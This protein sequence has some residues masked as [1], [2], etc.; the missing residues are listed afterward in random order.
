MERNLVEELRGTADEII[1]RIRQLIK[2]GSARRLLIK[3]QKGKVLM[4]VP[5]T[6]GVAGSTLIIAMAPVISAISMFALFIND[7]D[8]LVEK[9]PEAGENG[10]PN[11]K[12]EKEK[13]PYEVEAEYIT[14]KD[15]GEDEDG[16]DYEGED[17][18][19]DDD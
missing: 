15:E 18:N 14:I 16:D 1:K 5:L 7:V 4:E 9:Y 17:G 13:D 8:I 2:E 10:E 12:D 6:A 3:N 11:D 19:K